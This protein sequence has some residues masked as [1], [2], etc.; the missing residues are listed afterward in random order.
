M[1]LLYAKKGGVKMRVPRYPKWGGSLGTIKKGGNEMEEKEVKERVVYAPVFFVNNIAEE[2]NDIRRELSDNTLCVTKPWEYKNLMTRLD[3]C[4]SQLRKAVMYLQ[5][6]NVLGYGREVD[7]EDASGY[8]YWV[9][10]AGLTKEEVIEILE[11]CGVEVDGR[12]ICS[13]YDCTG[14][15]FCHSISFN[16]LRH[17]FGIRVFQYWGYDC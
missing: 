1:V 12:T 14:Q 6:P 9:F 13:E 11:R 16:R 15:Y 5:E 7:E 3:M 2:L 10:K 4:Q 8:N 17:K